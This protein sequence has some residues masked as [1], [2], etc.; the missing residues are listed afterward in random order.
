MFNADDYQDRQQ[1]A[2]GHFSYV[3]TC[4]RSKGDGP[5]DDLAMKVSDLPSESRQN[6]KAQVSCCFARSMTLCETSNVKQPSK[7]QTLQWLLWHLF[8]D[9]VI[10]C[11]P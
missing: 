4:S 9:D 2:N 5:P 11:T 1:I 6:E 3:F 8:P 7:N 10:M